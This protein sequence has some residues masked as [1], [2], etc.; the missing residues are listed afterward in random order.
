MSRIGE[1]KG[2]A[3]T[4][5]D[6]LMDVVGPEGC[7]LMPSFPTAGSMRELIDSGCIYDARSSPSRVGKVTE[8]FRCRP[9]VLRSL[10]PTNPL[11]AWGDGAKALLEDHEQS[12]TPYGYAT[13]YGRMAERDD[14]FILMIE[15]H[16]HSLLHHLQERVDFPTLFLPGTTAVPYIDEEGQQRTMTTR[17]MRP[18]VPYFI[19]IPSVKGVEPDWA[20]LHD[21]ALMFPARRSQEARNLGYRF[22]GYPRLHTRRS[23][24]ER[25]GILRSTKIGRGEAGLLN[26]QGFLARVEPELRELIERFRSYYDPDVIAARDLP[27][28]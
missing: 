23:E 2:G 16:V 19:A 22:R 28:G 11:A 1:I 15:T 5:I 12:L 3:D 24:L 7:I 13:P 20:I 27:Y 6:A 10:H 17:V 14:S 8:T 26:V 21:F 4:L 25:D 9:D 18:R